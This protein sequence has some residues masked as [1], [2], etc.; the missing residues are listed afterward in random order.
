VVDA[1][2]RGY[3]FTAR[4]PARALDDLLTA[5]PALTRAEQQAQLSALLPDL[6]P[7]PFD[8]AVLRAWSRWD[9]SHGLL[10][11]PVEIDRAFDLD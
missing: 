8:P 2:R 3:A 4:R 6:H 11:R 7:I 5:N 10:Q 1:A 9:A